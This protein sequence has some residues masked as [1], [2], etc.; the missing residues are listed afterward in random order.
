VFYL[1]VA[2]ICNGFQ[3]FHS[4]VSNVSFVFRRILQ[5]LHLDVLKVDWVLHILHWDPTAAATGGG[6]R[7]LQLLEE[8]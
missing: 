2:Y 7:S 1:D 3:V 4:H 8:A 5:V 6:M